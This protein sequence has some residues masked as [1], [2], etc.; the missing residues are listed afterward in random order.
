MDTSFG[1]GSANHPWIQAFDA[2]ASHYRRLHPEDAVC[3]KLAALHIGLKP[4]TEAD[5]HSLLGKIDL[6]EDEQEIV[7]KC[8]LIFEMRQ[9]VSKGEVK[10]DSALASEIDG[11]ETEALEA[12][13]KIAS[14]YISQE[15]EV[16]ELAL[17][18]IQKYQIQDETLRSQLAMIAAERNPRVCSEKIAQFHITTKSLRF[19]VAKVAMNSQAWGTCKNI[20]NYEIPEFHYPLA[21]IASKLDA[22][23]LAAHIKHFTLTP[24]QRLKVACLAAEQNPEAAAKNFAFEREDEKRTFARHLASISGKAASTYIKLSGIKE[25]EERYKIALIAFSQDPRGCAKLI[26]HY[27]LPEESQ[28]FELL[29]IVIENDSSKVVELIAEYGITH[30]E[31]LYELALLAASQ[32]GWKLSSEIPKLHLSDQICR[33]EV[34]KVAA[35][36]NGLG[37]VHFLE[38]YD[39]T[40]EQNF[41]IFQIAIEERGPS[42]IRHL[43]P[44]NWDISRRFQLALLSLKNFPLET[45]KD[46]REFELS[47]AYTHTVTQEATKRVFAFFFLNRAQEVRQSLASLQEL[48]LSPLLRESL[49][50]QLANPPK[51][52]DLPVFATLKNQFQKAEG[53]PLQA[54]LSTFGYACHFYEVTSVE[55]EPLVEQL[56]ALHAPQLRGELSVYCLQILSSDV[57]AVWRRCQRRDPI[58]ACLLAPVMEQVPETET[59]LSKIE[60]NRLF[61]DKNKQKVLYQAL[62]KIV[63]SCELTA[64][65]KADVLRMLFKAPQEKLLSS[66]QIAEDLLLFGRA[67][68]LVHIRSHQELEAQLLETFRA[69]FQLETQA[70]NYQETIGQFRN[71]IAPMTYAAKLASLPETEREWAKK[72]FRTYLQ[73]VLAGGL[74][75]VRYDIRAS[76]HLE[77]IFRERKELFEKWKRGESLLASDLLPTASSSL[78]VQDTDDACDLLLLGTEVKNSCLRVNGEAR[79]IKCLLAYLLDGKNRAV[80]VKENERIIGRCILRILW[81]DVAKKPVLFQE[82][83]YI[84]HDR[85]DVQKLL[86]KMCQRRAEDLGLTLVSSIEGDLKRYPNKIE[87]LGGRSFCE[88]V[89]ALKGHELTNSIFTLENCFTVI[90]Q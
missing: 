10:E 70:E 2:L 81:D 30:Q 57:K 31:Y 62:L 64:F 58:L 8:S 77:R 47:E 19:E 68:E 78:I 42:V 28:R 69:S 12:F 16:V 66:L 1:I 84:N 45:L 11:V 80:V 41:A 85:E 4:V 15:E 60:E 40:R 20:C 29:K 43:K 79:L 38:K 89:D 34:A 5:N 50:A 51:L 72:L 61:R 18:F 74:A 46:L 35:V 26:R 83:S 59:L 67:R 33:F 56:M 39:L 22:N 90:E 76:S 9:V 25:T 3:Q 21:K 32:D 23:A 65:E 44:W 52:L 82:K 37:A 53:E 55:L 71:K 75:D 73:A 87:S 86:S 24:K 17:S 54:W 63:T 27:Q 6:R 49:E 14:G 13:K 7:K 88:Y 36:Q 48:N